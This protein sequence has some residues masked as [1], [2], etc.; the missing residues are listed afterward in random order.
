M[1]SDPPSSIRQDAFLSPEISK[2]AAEVQ[3]SYP[4]HIALVHRLNRFAI[5]LFLNTQCKQ[6]RPGDTVAPAFMGRAIQ[7]FE[8]VVVLAL[9][10]MRAQARSM[11]RSTFET[12]CYCAAACRDTA[13][14]RATKGRQTNIVEAIARVH[15]KF[16]MHMAQELVPMPELPEDHRPKLAALGQ[17]ISESGN[18]GGIDLK[19]LTEDLELAGMYTVLFRQLSQDAHPNMTSLLHQCVV[20]DDRIASYRIGPDYEQFGDTITSAAAGLLLAVGEY[21]IRY[22]T[23]DD[24]KHVEALAAEYRQASTIPDP[25]VYTDEAQDISRRGST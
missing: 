16:R 25:E 3:E 10:G 14:V 13:L 11:A 21:S 23:D 12:A 22:G 7:D 9:N 6:E 15:Q 24:K 8:A 1:M 18:T 5:D 2:L 19:G 20:A 4:A 17:E